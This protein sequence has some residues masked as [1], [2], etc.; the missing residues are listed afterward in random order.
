MFLDQF[1]RKNKFEKEAESLR[2]DIPSESYSRGNF[3]YQGG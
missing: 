1:E 3:Q 2:G